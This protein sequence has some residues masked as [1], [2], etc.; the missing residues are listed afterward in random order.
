MGGFNQQ[1]WRFNLPKTWGFTLYNKWVMPQDRPVWTLKKIGGWEFWFLYSKTHQNQG[2]HLGFRFFSAGTR[3]FA[4]PFSVCATHRW[5]GRS[6]IW[7]LQISTYGSFMFVFVTSLVAKA[8]IFM[9]GKI[10]SR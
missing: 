3:H 8:T 7:S 9:V 10:I 2:I 1:N 4:R 5:A 6:H